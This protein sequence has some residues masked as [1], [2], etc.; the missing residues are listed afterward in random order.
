VGKGIQNASQHHSYC[1]LMEFESLTPT[2]AG[3]VPPTLCRLPIKKWRELMAFNR[4]GTQQT[5]IACS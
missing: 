1:L 2:I 4:Q 3:K 5:W